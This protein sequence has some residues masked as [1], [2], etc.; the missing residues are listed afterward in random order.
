MSATEQ[1]LHFRVGRYD[2]EP[3]WT[4]EVRG[5]VREFHQ[6]TAQQFNQVKDLALMGKYAKEKGWFWIAEKLLPEV[7]A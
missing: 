7:T 6:R 1:G 5:A 2:I 3:D 4:P